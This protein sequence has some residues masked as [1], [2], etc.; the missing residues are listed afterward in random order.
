LKRKAQL[1]RVLDGVS[2]G[3]I[4]GLVRGR[5][6]DIGKDNPMETWDG[7]SRPCDEPLVAAESDE[8]AGDTPAA[9]DDIPF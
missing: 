4:V 8:S 2:V 7:W 6:K 3:D 5:D 9:K 1:D